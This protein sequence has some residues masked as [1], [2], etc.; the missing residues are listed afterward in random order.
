[1]MN[2]VVLAQALLIFVILGAVAVYVLDIMTDITN[3]A[4][5]VSNPAATFLGKGYE[6][7]DVLG[8]FGKVIVVVAVVGVLVGLLG[9]RLGTPG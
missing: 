9:I 3:K 2:L 6:M 8:D 4:V 7:F 5:N 1:M